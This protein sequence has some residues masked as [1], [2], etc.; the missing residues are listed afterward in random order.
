MRYTVYL[1]CWIQ[2]LSTRRVDEYRRNTTFHTDIVTDQLPLTSHEYAHHN[3]SDSVAERIYLEAPP[4]Y[5]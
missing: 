5:T 1:A 3:D 4:T 2:I